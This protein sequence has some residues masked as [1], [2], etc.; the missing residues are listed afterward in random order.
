MFFFFCT[1]DWLLWRLRTFYSRAFFLRTITQ[2]ADNKLDPKFSS[3]AS[4]N[5]STRH[6]RFNT[7]GEWTIWML[8]TLVKARFKLS[9]W[10]LEQVYTNVTTLTWQVDSLFS[11]FGRI[12]ARKNVEISLKCASLNHSLVA[13]LLV[14]QVEHDVVLDRGVLDPSLSTKKEV[15]VKRNGRMTT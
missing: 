4:E 6:K 11:N 15:K 14:G 2:S 10:A 12:S 3:C 5:R 9:L 13:G 1:S 7:M 8:V